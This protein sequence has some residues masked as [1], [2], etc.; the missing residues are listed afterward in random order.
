MEKINVYMTKEEKIRL[1]T[2]AAMKDW[3]MTELLHN[4][5]V[6]GLK[7]REE[8]EG[9]ESLFWEKYGF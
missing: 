8:H 4:L 1:R 6:I 7:E 2:I 9:P 5:I 3:S